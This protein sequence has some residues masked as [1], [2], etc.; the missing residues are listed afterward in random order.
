[1]KAGNPARLGIRPSRAGIRA[2]LF[3]TLIGDGG[4]QR[5]DL[6]GVAEEIIPDVIQPV[7][8]FEDIRH[9]G[10]EIELRNRFVGDAFR[11]LMMPRRLLP[12]A[13]TS[14]ESWRASAGRDRKSV[15]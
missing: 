13:T 14:R 5:G 3:P 1:M 11:C 8:E 9:G 15:V 2:V 7:V 12:W 10:R 4:H 6:F